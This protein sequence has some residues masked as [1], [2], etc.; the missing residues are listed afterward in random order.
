VD[1][2]T[3]FAGR[4]E[5]VLLHK[6]D[7]AN[8]GQVLARIEISELLTHSTGPKP[9]HQQADESRKWDERLAEVTTSRG[10]RFETMFES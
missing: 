10:Q 9:Q 5:Q 3:K 7:T 4:I 6:D 2:A 1:I 8:G